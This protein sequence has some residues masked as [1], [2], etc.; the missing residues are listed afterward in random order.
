MSSAFRYRASLLVL[1]LLAA[2]SARAAAPRV[3][4]LPLTVGEGVSAQTAVSV[5]EALAAELRKLERAQLVTAQQVTAIVSL[6]RQRELIGCGKEACLTE[7]AGVLDVEQVV[8]G[9]VSRLGQSWLLQVQRLDAKTAQVLAHAS[10]REQ[11]S[12]DALLD[13]LPAMALELMGGGKVTARAPG[14]A[15]VSPASATRKPEE[16]APTPLP[17]PWANVPYTEPVDRTKLV[18]LTDGEGRYVAVTPF[19]IYG[20]HFAGD[21]EGLY[22]QRVIG[23]GSEG[24]KAYSFS[25]WEPRGRQQA[26]GHFD[27]REGRFKV[28]CDRKDHALQPVP[29]A[30]AKKLL[31][32]IKLYDVR[33]Q[34]Q[35]HALARDD[36]GTW[37]LTDQARLPEDNEDFRLYLGE[38]GALKAFPAKA[39]ARDRAGEIFRAADGRLKI[40]H[41]TKSAEW[42]AGDARRPLTL[43]DLHPHA[44]QIYGAN[45]PWAGMAL[46]TPCDGAFAQR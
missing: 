26:M 13:K 3:A 5:G 21:K 45:G 19:S 32:S 31:A 28:S 41:Q 46:G 44:S 24:G 10:T 23:G 2:G 43:L 15:S 40:D 17:A 38:P 18:L 8:T 14:T 25:F 11:G 1:V 7:L 30:Q 20:P 9:T 33:W 22:L 4:V 34:R 29:A 36:E 6:E 12:V 37:Y 27:M 39:L 16:A 35:A 42:I